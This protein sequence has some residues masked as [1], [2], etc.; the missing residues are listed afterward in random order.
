MLNI[1]IWESK[2]CIRIESVRKEFRFLLAFVDLVTIVLPAC[3]ELQVL[4]Q[5]RLLTY[6]TTTA[7]RYLLPVG[8]DWS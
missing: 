3:D 7:W 4:R 6:R 2:T 1:C 8:R 5:S